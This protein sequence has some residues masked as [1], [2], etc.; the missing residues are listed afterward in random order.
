LQKI[1]GALDG[2]I[3]LRGNAA[4]YEAWEAVLEIEIRRNF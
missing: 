3:A 1:L 4:M 2:V